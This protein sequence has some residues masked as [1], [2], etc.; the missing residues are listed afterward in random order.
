MLKRFTDY[1]LDQGDV[2][3]NKINGL[4]V[5]AKIPFVKKSVSTAVVQKAL[6]TLGNAALQSGEMITQTCFF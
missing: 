6:I 2:I 3:F 5:V 4:S 1:F